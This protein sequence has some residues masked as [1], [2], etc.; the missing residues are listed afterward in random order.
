MGALVAMDKLPVASPSEEGKKRTVVAQDASGANVP[1]HWEDA[2]N[3]LE[4]V[5]SGSRGSVRVLLA[6]RLVSNTDCSVLAATLKSPN[7]SVAVDSS[8]EMGASTGVLPPPP[9]PVPALIRKPGLLTR[10]S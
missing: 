10:Y 4:P 8:T 6:L 7:A 9:L 5:T 2:L 3:A 1:P